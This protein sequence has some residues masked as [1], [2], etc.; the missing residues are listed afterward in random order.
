[1]GAVWIGTWEGGRIRQNRKGEPVFMIE[2]SVHGR[3]MAITLEVGSLK[4]A[5]RELALFEINPERYRQTKQTVEGVYLTDE[6]VKGY[7]AHLESQTLDE[8]YRRDLISYLDRWLDFLAG[9]DISTTTTAELKEFIAKQTGAKKWWITTIKSLC[10]YMREEIAVLPYAMDPSLPIKIPQARPE[11]DRRKKGFDMAVIEEVYRRVPQ[12]NVR[13]L[14]MVQATTGLHGAEIERLARGKGRIRELDDQGEIAA[15]VSYPQKT[16]W[17]VRSIEQRTLEALK[18][19]RSHGLVP[20]GKWVDRCLD[21]ACKGMA[22]NPKVRMGALRHSF[23]TWSRS[24]GGR[25]VYPKEAGVP[26]SIIAQ[27]MNHRTTRTTRTFYDE[28]EIPEMVVVPIKLEHPDDARLATPPA[29]SPQS[30]TS[31]T[32]GADTETRTRP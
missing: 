18:R 10:G 27:A 26:L 23:V 30:G 22:G 24:K 32:P 6:R 12:Q 29:T 9:R 31:Q 8:Y 11:K 7:K 1:M 14:L 4:E 2:R 28:T 25:V 5:K 17:H 3:R 21:A 16:G 20:D 19:L 15:T 13:D